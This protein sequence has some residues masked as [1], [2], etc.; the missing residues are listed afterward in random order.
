MSFNTILLLYYCLLITLSYS[1]AVFLYPHTL[2]H[3]FILHT[4]THTYIHTYIHTYL[5]TY[6]HTYI[7]T[8]TNTYIHTYI[9]GS[10]L[11]TLIGG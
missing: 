4:Y 9:Q 3:N 11:R 5:H 1:I 8:K 2:F 10:G 7:H 6:I